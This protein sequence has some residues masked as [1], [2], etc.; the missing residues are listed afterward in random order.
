MSNKSQ[1]LQK[2]L[3]KLEVRTFHNEV[4]QISSEDEI[5]TIS[6]FRLG[7]T[8]RVEVSWDE[9]NAALGQVI[10][11]ICVQAHH[12]GYSFDEFHLHACGAFSQISRTG[13]K[14]EKFKLFMPTSEVSF[15]TG[16]EM[17]LEAVKRFI[18]WI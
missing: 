6:G 11:L 17:L 7:C 1:S 8:Q 18:D 13:N 2:Q 9:R 5:A 4:F 10:Y 12:L 16:M 15:N 3:G 14:K